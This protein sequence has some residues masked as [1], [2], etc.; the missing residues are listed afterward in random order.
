MPAEGSREAL[1]D[2]TGL[3]PQTDPY[4]KSCARR[5][6]RIDQ[7]EQS[8]VAK[9]KFFTNFLARRIGSMAPAAADTRTGRDRERGEM[10]DRFYI[11][12]QDGSRSEPWASA[13]F[14]GKRELL[15]TDS[16]CGAQTQE[17][18]RGP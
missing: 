1:Q 17:S 7:Q 9:L 15:R 14:S 6:N 18:R 13:R 2:G 3:L 8:A 12:V 16:T 5:Y 11:I 4:T 10:D